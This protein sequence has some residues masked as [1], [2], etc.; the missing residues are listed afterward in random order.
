M[1]RVDSNR[2]NAIVELPIR[3]LAPGVQGVP[4]QRRTA[5]RSS[6]HVGR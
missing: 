5:C 2:A 1:I 6:Y 4:V 3:V